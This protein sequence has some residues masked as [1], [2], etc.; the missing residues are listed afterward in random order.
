[1]TDPRRPLA[2]LLPVTLLGLA[3]CDGGS[4]ETLPIDHRFL[5]T[6]HYSAPEQIRNLNVD[7]RSDLYSLGAILYEVMTGRRPFT[8]DNAVNV[9]MQHLNELP[10]PPRVHDL[11]VFAGNLLLPGMR[12][13]AMCY[14]G[15]QFGHW[16]GQLG[17]GRAINLGEVPDRAG[18]LQMLQLKGAGPT[19]YSRTADGLAVL[20]SSVREFLCSE[21]M[22]HLGIPTTRALSLTLTGE[23]VVRDMFYD[24]N[25]ALEPGA[26][27]CRVAPSFLRF[28]NFEILVANREPE[29]LVQLADFTI[30]TLFPHLGAP[31]KSTYVAWFEEVCRRT[32]EMVVRTYSDV[33]VFA[34][35]P[36][37]R[38]E[39]LA[40]A[41]W[42]IAPE[43]ERDGFGNR[44]DFGGPWRERGGT[45]LLSALQHRS[46]VPC[47]GR[48]RT[49]FREGPPC[50]WGS[51][52][53]PTE[54][55]IATART[56]SSL[57]SAPR[58][59]NRSPWRSVSR[60]RAFT[61]CG[62][63]ITS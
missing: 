29:L 33:R 9:A 45:L 14:G 20:R 46:G 19:P 58:R 23:E 3:A 35:R 51:T 31:G 61:R 8:G 1:M 44:I 21:A 62:S 24:G 5:G 16:A 40:N 48:V 15:H 50:S 49:F 6:V 42:I 54:S 2:F 53:P 27:V 38:K 56:S 18:T 13:H 30:R 28:G 12:P 43:T 37:I 32:A 4:D 63:P 22:H 57:P 39:T 55:G 26:V 7:G 10:V 52:P 36:G 11:D 59:C 41:T 17:D 60:R 47:A 25:A 34:F